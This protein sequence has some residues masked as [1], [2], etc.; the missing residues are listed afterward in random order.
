[1]FANQKIDYFPNDRFEQS[2]YQEHD[3]FAYML[4]KRKWQIL[5]ITFTIIFVLANL[6]VW[7]RSPIYQSQAILQFSS[8][9]NLATTADTDLWQQ[10]IDVTRQ[11]LM[12]DSVLSNL[13]NKLASDKDIHIGLPELKSMLSITS[14]LTSNIIILE[15]RGVDSNQLKPIV[16]VWIS[17]YLFILEGENNNQ[18]QDELAVL[19]QQLSSIQE[20]IVVQQLTVED[21]AQANEI[22]SLERD[23]N[24]I[25]S[26]IKGLSTNLE[27][28][29]NEKT[30]A[31]ATL[32]N[33]NQSVKQGM[34][35]E[36]PSDKNAISAIRNRLNVIQT[37]LKALKNK[38]TDEY[39]A[40]DP[41]LVAKQQ[42]AID[43]EYNLKQQINESQIAYLTDSQRVL[44]VAANKVGLLRVQLNEQRK[45]AQ[46]FNQKLEQYKRLEGEL[47]ELQRQEQLLKNRLVEK[48]LTR[49]FET[50]IN[51]LEPASAAAYPVGPNYWQDTLI[52]LIIATAISLLAL[53]LFSFIV[54]PRD[55][56]RVTPNIVVVPHYGANPIDKITEQRPQIGQVAPPVAKL[57]LSH[58][59]EVV[60]T[61]VLQI[62]ESKALYD[63]ANRQGKTLIG[64]LFCGLTLEEISQLTPADFVEDFTKLGIKGNAKRNLTIPPLFTQHLKSSLSSI[65]HSMPILLS[66]LSEEDLISLVVNAAYDAELV[67]P[68][69]ISIDVL[70][71]TYIRFLIDQGVKLND[72]EVICGFIAPAELAHLRRFKQATKSAAIENIDINYPFLS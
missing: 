42:E 30:Q 36:R 10:V 25:L 7:L 63:S 40:R 28:A 61:R 56:S 69:Q 2:G 13:S 31:L 60:Q 65:E 70:R 37:E 68:E 12:S 52:A 17:D 38:Y 4:Q 54:R 72:I 23:E 66:N 35:I 15:A 3:K 39:L 45:V 47:Q 5:A 48:E 24:Q 33:L 21:F 18:N 9:N 8:P 14:N 53:G 22:I 62:N 51:I 59:A 34:V 44:E 49:P 11:R 57:G 20:K 67:L 41:A 50:K 6:F 32:E 26:K 16:D 19:Q 64:L 27:V 58:S 1:M 55:G 43:L 29:E 46:Q 71:H